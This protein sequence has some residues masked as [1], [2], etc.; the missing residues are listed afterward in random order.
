MNTQYL[1]KIDKLRSPQQIDL[2]SERDGIL[3]RALPY[4]CSAGDRTSN[5][6]CLKAV[7]VK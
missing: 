4:L 2:S 3:S 1:P 7:F 6:K 5:V